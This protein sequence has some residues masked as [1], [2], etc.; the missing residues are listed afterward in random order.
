MSRKHLKEAKF[1]ATRAIAENMNKNTFDEAIPFVDYLNRA[2]ATL[3]TRYENQC[4]YEWACTEKYEGATDKREKTLLKNAS[5]F[6][7]TVTD[8]VNEK[9]PGSF[10]RLQGDPRGW[11]IELIFNTPDTRNTYRLGGKS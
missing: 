8:D 6:G 1:Q 3:H 9:R 7:F 10:I 5:E 11:P 4:S 2:G